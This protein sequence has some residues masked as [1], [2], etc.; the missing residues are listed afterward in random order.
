MNRPNN[1][2]V[3]R[4]GLFLSSYTA[5]CVTSI[6]LWLVVSVLASYFDF[7][8]IENWGITRRRRRRGNHRKGKKKK[9]EPPRSSLSLEAI[10]SPVTWWRA[11]WI[12]HALETERGLCRKLL[13]PATRDTHTQC[14][15]VIFICFLFFRFLPVLSASVYYLVFPFIWFFFNC[16]KENFQVKV[17]NTSQGLGCRVCGAR[18]LYA[19][20]PHIHWKVPRLL[21]QLPWWRRRRPPPVFFFFFIFCFPILSCVIILSLDIRIICLCVEE[22]HTYLV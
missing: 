8:K 15:V 9:K 21:Y 16:K 4:F 12:L 19:I 18:L 1:R 10:Q 22:A 13:P 3:T 11:Y 17:F 7:G 14:F 5:R 2:Q 20:S 6:S